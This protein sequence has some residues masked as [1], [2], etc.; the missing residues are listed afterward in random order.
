MTIL[1]L[2]GLYFFSSKNKI[3]DLFVEF[4]SKLQ[5][6]I[7]NEVLSIRSNYDTLLKNARFLEYCV[8]YGIDN[9]FVASMAPQ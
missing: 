2:H 1:A 3:Y 7:D 9:N 4:V 5:R 8:N 6:K